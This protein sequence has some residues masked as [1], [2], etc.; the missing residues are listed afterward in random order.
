MR[1]VTAGELPSV[2]TDRGGWPWTAKAD[3][4]VADELPRI[5][6]VT[7]SL[8]QA[9]FLEETIRSVLLQGYPNL[10]YIVVDGGSSDGSIETIRKYA[11]WLAHWESEKDRGQSHA[12][13]KGFARATGEILAWLNS[14]DFLLPGALAAVA[15]AFR[16]HGEAG[17]VY[18]G[19]Q[20]VDEA[21][22]PV[23]TAVA[24]RDFD[25]GSLLLGNFIAQPSAFF[26]RTTFE[27][28]GPLDEELHMIM[29]YDLWIRIASAFPVIAL[30]Q[31]LS[32]FRTHSEQKTFTASM[33]WADE[34]IR[35]YRDR[36]PASLLEDSDLENARRRSL[37]YVLRRR[38]GLR[39][40]KGSFL[41]A[42]CDIAQSATVRLLG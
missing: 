25:L 22:H 24:A 18:G 29:D 2:P 7:P 1:A 31:V 12:I 14:D 3:E 42:S 32:A 28:S 16:T 8:N 17:L 5:T 15:T 13:N 19:C 4:W 40:K 20:K 41:E 30:P 34:M 35:V 26:R 23:A 11:K 39:L 10:E 33:R 38:A 9:Q 6:I 36:I 21:G 27:K 37:S